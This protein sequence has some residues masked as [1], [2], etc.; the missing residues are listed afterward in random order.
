MLLGRLPRFSIVGSPERHEPPEDGEGQLLRDLGAGHQREGVPVDAV[1]E[2]PSGRQA[3]AGG[4][5][6]IGPSQ[7]GRAR[8]GACVKLDRG[9]AAQELGA[10]PRGVAALGGQT[11]VPGPP[12]T[13]TTE[14]QRPARGERRSERV[15]GLA[16]GGKSGRKD[17]N[18]VRL[19]RRTQLSS[20][21][22]K[23]G[24]RAQ[25]GSK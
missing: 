25:H 20:E 19:E 11:G 4:S 8:G 18:G 6:G 7:A 10:A 24:V 17:T 5:A 22:E 16:A 15:R 9:S 3:V 13:G 2:L 21:L 12:Q 23:H 14:R 1:R